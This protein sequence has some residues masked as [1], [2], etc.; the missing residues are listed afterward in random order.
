MSSA[1]HEFEW[2]CEEVQ[3]RLSAD[4]P[5]KLIDC[6]EPSEFALVHLDDAELIPMNDTPSRLDDY[7]AG[8]GPTVVYCHHGV[9]S[10]Q[11]VA[12]LRSQGVEDVWSMAGG[13][14]HWSLTVDP[15]KPR[16]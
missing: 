2:S 9:R 15:S 8:A 11:V 5:P 7:R 6:R 3:K 4:G 16:Y 12:W 13:I 1:L 14:D 10:L